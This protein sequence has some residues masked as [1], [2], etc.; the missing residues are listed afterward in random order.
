MSYEKIREHGSPY[1]FGESEGVYPAEAPVTEVEVAQDT[2]AVVVP[3][4]EDKTIASIE[5]QITYAESLI[6][7][8]EA[9]LAPAVDLESGEI[10]TETVLVDSATPGVHSLDDVDTREE[11]VGTILKSEL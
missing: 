3:V 10:V 6:E 8:L 9:G 1:L 11:N 2:V 4:D 5:T 7:D